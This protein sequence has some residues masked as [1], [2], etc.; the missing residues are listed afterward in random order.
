M[1]NKQQE[2]FVK[3]CESIDSFKGKFF[4]NFDEFEHTIEN[5]K[6]V[7]SVD[8]PELKEKMSNLVELISENPEMIQKD[9]ETELWNM[10]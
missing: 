4:F 7:E 5:R 8:Y 6:I 3:M 1:E 10:I 9:I 2:I